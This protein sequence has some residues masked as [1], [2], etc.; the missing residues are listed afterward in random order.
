MG[1]PIDLELLISR[2]HVSDTFSLTNSCR[3]LA[4]FMPIDLELCHM[5]WSSF[6]HNWSSWQK[7]CVRGMSS[8]CVRNG[9]W[10]SYESWVMCY[11]LCYIW[12]SWCN[13]RNDLWETECERDVSSLDVFFHITFSANG[14]ERQCVTNSCL[15]HTSSP[16][17]SRTL[18]LTNAFRTHTVSHE[19][20]SH[21]LFFSRIFFSRT[22][23]AH[24]RRL[25]NSCLTHISSHKLM[26]HTTC[27]HE[28]MLHTH[29]IS[30]THVSHT[31]LLTNS[32]FT[33]LVLTNSRTRVH[34][35]HTMWCGRAASASEVHDTWK[36]PL[37]MDRW[38]YRGP[39]ILQNLKIC[40]HSN[41]LVLK[42]STQA[43]IQTH[44]H[45]HTLMST[46]TCMHTDMHVRSHTQDKHTNTNPPHTM[47]THI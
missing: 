8:W 7:Q 29:A 11:E 20:M 24:T 14:N 12:M 37:H 40:M 34:D 27:S 39:E 6:F 36:D 3:T 18:L 9:S 32:C 1:M 13:V 41:P 17:L 47:H 5:G 23:V 35:F 43:Y 15:T 45:T 21:T 42:V 2:T 19:H 33:Q 30:Q 25:P 31:S 4:H 28:L 38:I 26:F 10:E 22:H 16:E 44:T 46:H